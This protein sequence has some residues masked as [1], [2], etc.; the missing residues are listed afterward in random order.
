MSLRRIALCILIAATTAF[1]A[2]ASQAASVAVEI[3]AAPPP[4]RVVVV[5]PPRVGHVWVPG[6]W[7]WNGHR[8]I[9]VN[10]HWVRERRGWHWVPAQWVEAG[11]RWR[12]VPGHWER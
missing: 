9:W 1:G 6:Y 5:P 12:F 4:P 3:N 11:P 2:G 8:H 7:R 10:G